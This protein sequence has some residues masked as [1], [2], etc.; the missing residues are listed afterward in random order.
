M[1][2]RDSFHIK[3]LIV[4]KERQYHGRVE[5]LLRNISGERTPGS[6]LQLNFFD[7]QGR[8]RDRVI[9]S[10]KEFNPGEERSVSAL[11]RLKN[12]EFFTY[13]AT[14]KEAGGAG[15]AD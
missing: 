10:M 1:A 15:A 8:I 7:P 13:R 3:Y 14:I 4:K 12:D 2:L 6:I 9:V 5:A 11:F